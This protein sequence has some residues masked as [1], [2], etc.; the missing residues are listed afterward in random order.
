MVTT[1][2]QTAWAQ[3][4]VWICKCWP[5]FLKRPAP[6]PHPHSHHPYRGPRL[7]P[8]SFLANSAHLHCNG[9]HAL[10]KP[11]WVRDAVLALASAS[12]CA[13][14]TSGHA[15]LGCRSIAQLFNLAHAGHG[16][17]VSKSFVYG[18]LKDRAHALVLARLRA[19][20]R[21]V[22]GAG[23]VLR[24]WGMDL[25]G[26]PLVDG[27][28]VPVFGVIDHGSRAIVELVPLVKYNALILL[29][30]L[31]VAFG[32]FGKPAAVRCDNDAVFK[33]VVFRGVLSLLG[34]QQQFTQIASPWQNGRIERLW[35]TLKETLGTQ[36]LRYSEGV[37]V[38]QTRMKLASLTA[39][40]EVLDAFMAHYNHARPHQSLAGQT[41]GMVW[42]GQVHKKLAKVQAEAKLQKQE[43]KPA[44][45]HER[46]RAPPG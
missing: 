9:A 12:A 35:R 17:S 18:L 29:G 22:A 28:S 44:A 14:S 38:V 24:T 43:T 42:N 36:P 21:P 40:I 15:V 7:Q 16:F 23:A 46:P 34:V 4:W 26:L 13:P 27:S 5:C 30:K 37:R 32:T 11:D 19:G 8:V 45:A 3:L 39:M 31:L 10:R 20:N 41:P 33:T 6:H 2:W 25:T 1:V